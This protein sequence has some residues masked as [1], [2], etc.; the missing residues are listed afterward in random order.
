MRII[1]CLCVINITILSASEYFRPLDIWGETT[2]GKE[3]KQKKVKQEDEVKGTI[4]VNEL[5]PSQD[6]FYRTSDGSMAFHGAELEM[7]KRP[8]VTNI[9]RVI[10]KRK[11][12]DERIKIVSSRYKREVFKNI[13]KKVRPTNKSLDNPNKYIV[14]LYYTSYCPSCASVIKTTIPEL[15]KQKIKIDAIQTNLGQRLL[16]ISDVRCRKTT[17]EELAFIKEKKLNVPFFVMKNIYTG[18]QKIIQG[19]KTSKEIIS[20]LNSIGG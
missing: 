12:M 11:L 20:N 7:M 3:I 9:K 14:K 13:Y 19:F 10:K 18:K 15:I 4:E 16:E 17:Y 2:K 6:E 1:V 5:D 8:T